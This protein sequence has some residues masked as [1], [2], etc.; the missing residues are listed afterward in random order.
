MSQLGDNSVPME[1]L[2]LFFLFLFLSFSLQ[3][4]VVGVMY[5]NEFMGHLHKSATKTSNS[6]T[7]IQCSQP[8]KVLEENGKFSSGQWFYVSVGNDKGYIHSQFLQ[9]SRP[10]C[11]QER[12]PRFYQKL[13][14]DL[15]DMYY[16][17][18]LQDHFIKAI[19]RA[20]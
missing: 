11:F 15:S 2:K 19:T 4:K 3:A 20:Q 14:L 1:S 12:Y 17:G 16:F 7:T 5:F 10:E 9:T 18:R 13:E 6:L 8:V